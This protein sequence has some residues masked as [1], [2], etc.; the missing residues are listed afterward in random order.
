MGEY[1]PLWINLPPKHVFG[2]RE[3]PA[4]SYR[5]SWR[6]VQGTKKR[7]KGRL[8]WT[9]HPHAQTTPLYV[10]FSFCACGGEVTDVITHAKFH[11]NRFSSFGS[12]GSRNSP[13]PHR[14]GEWLLQQC[15]GLT[16]YTVIS[17]FWTWMLTLDLFAVANLVH[18]SY[19]S[20]NGVA[21][22]LNGSVKYR[23]GGLS[24]KRYNLLGPQHTV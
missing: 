5:V 20:W 18:S 11:L 23:Y 12:P 9:F 24:R 13:S 10:H 7:K 17:N 8:G 21:E 6:C 19:L 3:R 15:Y 22:L 14:L 2:R 1:H 16:C 4:N